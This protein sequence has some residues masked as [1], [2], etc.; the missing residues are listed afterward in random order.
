M[1][2]R[3]ALDLATPRVGIHSHRIPIVDLATVDTLATVAGSYAIS[4]LTGFSFIKTTASMF[5]LSVLVHHWFNID[6]VLHQKF[7]KLI[8]KQMEI[9]ADHPFIDENSTAICPM[10]HLWKSV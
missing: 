2:Q 9:P 4:R 6:T 5:G 1:Q 8:G 10:M 7:M 3:P